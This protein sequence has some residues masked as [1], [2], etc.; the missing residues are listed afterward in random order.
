M[1]VPP[2]PNPSY[3]NPQ[4]GVPQPRAIEAPSSVKGAFVIYVVTAL[5][6]LV[7]IVITLTSDIYDRAINE[8]ANAG[9]VTGEISASQIV[10]IAKTVTIVVGVLFLALYLFFAV[11]MRAGRNW[12]RIVLTVLSGLSI[13]SVANTGSVTVNNRVYSSSMSLISGWVGAALAVLAIV[14]LY[15]AASNAYFRDVKAAK[16]RLG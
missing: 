4:Y 12:A 1:S 8:A 3:P 13:L 14:F 6:S 5:I 10:T 9:A 2:Y 11:K 16:E 7:G 15:L